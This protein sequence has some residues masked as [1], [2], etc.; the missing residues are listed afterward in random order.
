MSERET[1]GQV[2]ARLRSQR[3][4]SQNRLA[5]AADFD[6][7]YISRLESG[8]RPP[9]RDALERISLALGLNH[10]DHKLLVNAGGYLSRHEATKERDMDALLL[11]LDDEAI[12]VDIREA[13][14]LSLAGAL[15]ILQA[16]KSLALSN[17]HPRTNTVITEGRW[18]H[19]RSVRIDQRIPAD[20]AVSV[21]LTEG[22][23]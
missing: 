5:E 16:E 22:G 14:R 1:V 7:S 17:R 13:I 9:T 20:R 15:T 8:K 3:G 21:S 19:V 10:A 18:G 11:L 4:L 23:S 2:M 12:R 6:H